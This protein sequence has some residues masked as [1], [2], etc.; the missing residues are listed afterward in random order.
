MLKMCINTYCRSVRRKLQQTAY[1]YGSCSSV[2]YS[3]VTVPIPTV[4]CQISRR[5][6]CAFFNHG[7]QVIDLQTCRNKIYIG[8]KTC[9]KV[10]VI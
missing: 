1:L 4:G 6:S 5:A 8:K 3:S 7:V 2:T 10:V 9:L